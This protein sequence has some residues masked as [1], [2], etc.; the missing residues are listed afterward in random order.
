LALAEDGTWV[1]QIKSL[2]VNGKAN[3][4]LN[5]LVAAQMGC[6]KVAMSIKTG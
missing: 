1:V 4:E 6:A 2:P 5:G 3:L